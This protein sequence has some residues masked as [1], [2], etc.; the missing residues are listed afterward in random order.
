MNTKAANTN[1]GIK[2]RISLC[3]L[4]LKK[5][6]AAL[7]TNKDEKLELLKSLPAAPLQ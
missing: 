1:N 5:I 6:E 2:I 4:W 3:P 7:P